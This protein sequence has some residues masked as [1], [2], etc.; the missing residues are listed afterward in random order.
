MTLFLTYSY[1]AHHKLGTN[2]QYPSSFEF[3]SSLNQRPIIEYNCV[4]C[5]ASGN[6]SPCNRAERELNYG[7]VYLYTL[8]LLAMMLCRAQAVL[9]M[10]EGQSST[11]P[12]AILL[13]HHK[14]V[15][16]GK[17][18]PGSGAWPAGMGPHQ[19]WLSV[20]AW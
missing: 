20:A 3:I 8:L 2:H 5:V 9:G 1:W 18:N 6:F 19:P 16:N 15:L 12:P 14:A 13:G 11:N 4:V 17:H 10:H 7:G